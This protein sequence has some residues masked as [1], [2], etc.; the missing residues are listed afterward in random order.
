MTR[1]Y[2]TINLRAIDKR[3]QAPV[4]AEMNSFR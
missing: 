1:N 4:A 2:T 3:G